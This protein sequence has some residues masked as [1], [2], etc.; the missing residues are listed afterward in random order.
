[1]PEIW[2]IKSAL[3]WTIGYLRRKGDP[4]PRLSAQWLMSHATNLSRVELY[5][6]YDKPLNAVERAVL[7]D[8]VERRGKCEPLQYIC[9]SASFR[10]IVLEVE[11][12]VLIPRPETEV[13]VEVALSKLPE[14]AVPCDNF[15]VADIGTGSG[16][17]ACSIASEC[18]DA[19]VYATDIS[20]QAICVA[21][22]NADK[23]GLSLRI[24]FVQCNLGDDIPKSTI[25][26][27]SLV[28]S[29]PPYIP[30]T[31]IEELDAEVKDYEPMLALDGGEDGLDVFK[32]LLEWA[33]YALLPDGWLC[34]ELHE[35]CL[36]DACALARNCGFE[37][38][39]IIDDLA[40]KHRVLAAQKPSKK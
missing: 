22:K 9:G 18:E 20:S 37:N 17:I 12:G 19:L 14:T 5:T 24:T 4:N 3:E 28:V 36:E 1:M 21:S 35:E 33:K 26:K 11:P 8:A 34:V 27:F 25:G 23:L 7:H 39:E 31:L 38:C 29:N 30:S 16:C 6:N 10:R 40:G 15:Y 13:L 2:T 32:E